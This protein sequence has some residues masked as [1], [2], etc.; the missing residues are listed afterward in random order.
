MEMYTDHDHIQKLPN[1]HHIPK[2]GS[3]S[4]GNGTVREIQI[5]YIRVLLTENS[6]TLTMSFRDEVPQFLPVPET[7]VLALQAPLK[8]ELPVMLHDL[9]WKKLVAAGYKFVSN[10]SWSP[11]M[12][13]QLPPVERSFGKE[14]LNDQASLDRAVYLYFTLPINQA[15]S[16]KYDFEMK[17]DTTMELGNTDLKWFVSYKENGRPVTK[18]VAVLGLK[19][20]RSIS[21]KQYERTICF[22]KNKPQE[23][24]AKNKELV[25]RGEQLYGNNAEIHMKQVVRKNGVS[26]CRFLGIYDW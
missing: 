23:V 18:C 9:D 26:G 12:T 20:R 13:A 22:P 2:S 14:P 24:I 1:N 11:R 17:A 15:L 7:K 16:L 5:N 3:F 6:T 8:I 21:P 10:L 4:S 19:D 25:E